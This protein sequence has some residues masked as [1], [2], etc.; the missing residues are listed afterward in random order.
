MLEDRAVLT[1]RLTN[2]A[3]LAVNSG[4]SW[5]MVADAS[6][7][8]V[9]M[10]GGMI[11]F[12]SGDAFRTLTLDTLA[13][14]GNFAMGTNL[15]TYTG[16][17]LKITGNASGDFSLHI[18]NTGVEPVKGDESLKMVETSGGDAKFGAAGG[19]VDVGT[20]QYVMEQQGNDWYLVRGLDDTGKPIVTPSTDI[21]LGLFSTA[22]TVWYG[23]MSSLRSRM[24]ELRMGKLV[25]GAWVR[26]YGRKYDVSSGAG[27]GYSQNQYG[28]SAGTD[29][30]L[31][32]QSGQVIFGGLAGYSKSDLDFGAGTTGK[33]DS[34]YVGTYAT[35]IADNGYYLDALVKLNNFR[36][37][38][39]VR[40][41]DGT[42][43]DGNYSSYGVGTS[44]EF[45]RRIALSDNWFVEPMGQ[46]SALW[47]K[48]DNY[49]LSNGLNADNGHTNSVQL[50]LGASFGR[51][52]ILSQGSKLQPYLK[53]AV[54]QE[55]AKHNDVNVNDNKFNND[56]SGTRGE[57]GVGIAAQLRANLQLHAD[58]DY[59]K[60]TNIRQPWGINVGV[61]YNW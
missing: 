2:V 5:N 61:R 53:A 16:D 44:V 23:E 11:N 7:A 24:G 35:W 1:G 28:L 59:S 41:S 54:V 36:N 51:T 8:T 31:A 33:V 22:P 47:V 37:Q 38:A 20:Y 48:G 40:M 57:V 9:N 30:A 50:K 25:D 17:L 21:V 39:N 18:K 32:V 27:L 60:G 52:L 46:L 42:Q 43:A 19:K 26:T 56:L 6:V 29:K 15:A 55:F 12:N 4:A 45:G 14:N 3:N 13:G 10:D 34:Y 58:A 49:A